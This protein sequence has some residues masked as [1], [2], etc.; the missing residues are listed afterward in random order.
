MQL[1]DLRKYGFLVVLLLSSSLIMFSCGDDDDDDEPG[2]CTTEGLTYGNYA[3]DF[4]I[5][6]CSTLGGCHVEANKDGI[7]S[8]ETYEDAKELVDR[9]RIIGAI[10]HQDGFSNMPKGEEKLDD[11]S[12]DKLTAWVNDGAPE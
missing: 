6:N 11:C 8:F 3:E 2:T 12:I 9:G 5:N 7:G 10:N 1:L 4:L